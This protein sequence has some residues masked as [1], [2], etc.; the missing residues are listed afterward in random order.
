LSKTGIIVMNVSVPHCLKGIRRIISPLLSAALFGLAVWVIYGQMH[1]YRFNDLV[2]SIRSI[3]QSKLAIAGGLTLFNYAVMTGYD[4]LAMRYIRRSL[5]YPKTAFVAILSTVI[6]NN[7][8]FPLLVSSAL[9]YRFYSRW[10]LSAKDVAGLSVFCHIGCGIGQMAVGG[11]V[12]LVEPMQI[13]SSLHLPMSSLQPL[14]AMSLTLVAFY[15]LGSAMSRTSIKVWKW[16]IPH[17]PLQVS[18]PQLAIASL[19]WILAAATIYILLPPLPG[20]SYPLCLGIYLV[21]QFAGVSS[22]VPGGLGVFE[23]VMLLLLRPFGNAGEVLGGLLAFRGIYH[24]LP[25]VVSL[26]AWGVYSLKRR[27][28]TRKRSGKSLLRWV[29]DFSVLNRFSGKR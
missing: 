18:L 14:G 10:G 3:P 22:H 9:R 20:L 29:M 6:C 23:T 19:D 26:S 21:A 8:G 2:Q 11:F 25:L 17:L 13:P 5:S 1:Q 27:G 16:R 28:R 24:L 7:V 12:F 15:L 4:T